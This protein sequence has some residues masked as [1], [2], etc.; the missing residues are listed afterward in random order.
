VILGIGRGG[1][2][3]EEILGGGIGM[4]ALQG[5]QGGP[6]AANPIF[7]V[8][9]ESFKKTSAALEAID[10]ALR[11]ASE[12]PLTQ[13]PDQLE[14]I[15]ESSGLKPGNFIS[16]LSHF[17]NAKASPGLERP[18]TSIGKEGSTSNHEERGKNSLGSDG[19]TAEK[20][21]SGKRALPNRSTNASLTSSESVAVNFDGL[22]QP[23]NRESYDK[24]AAEFNTLSK[25]IVTARTN[26]EPKLEEIASTSAN[27][28]RFVI[29][30]V[31]N[32]DLARIVNSNLNNFRSSET[33]HRNLEVGE[34]QQ[35]PQSVDGK[36]V[37][38][39]NNFQLFDRPNRS[40]HGHAISLVEEKKPIP[41]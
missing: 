25:P 34:I 9:R 22:K 12:K 2:F 37:I 16:A 21:Y 10:R 31:G 38:A 6:I 7:Q 26:P 36:L 27:K 35:G 3:G 28:S 29:T 4:V 41:A 24:S 17:S 40:E 11:A 13:V 33:A 8:D 14:R 18:D 20:L 15:F 5:S 32:P 23:F 19:E 30:L 39:L 1:G